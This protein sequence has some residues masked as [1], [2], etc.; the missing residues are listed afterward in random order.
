MK[1]CADLQSLKKITKQISAFLGVG[2]FAT[3]FDYLVFL[4][5]Y[6][7]IEIESVISALLGYVVGGVVSYR[8]TRRFVFESSRSHQEALWRFFSIVGLGFLLTGLS[9]RMLVIYFE[10]PP[11]FARIITYGVVLI[12]NFFAHRLFTFRR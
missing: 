10:L 12:F 3:A 6:R 7:F 1:R 4:F 2:V 9:M 8:L 11:S 5:A